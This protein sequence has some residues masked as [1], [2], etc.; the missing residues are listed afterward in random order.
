[1]G[2]L[3]FLGGMMTGAIFGILFAALMVMAGRE[4]DARMD[5]KKEK[6]SYDR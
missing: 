4:D 3:I 2:V 6:S 1:M 5:E